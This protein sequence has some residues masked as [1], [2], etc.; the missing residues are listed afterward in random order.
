M[1]LN[2][3]RR[4]P[5]IPFAAAFAA[6]GRLRIRP[7]LRPRTGPGAALAAPAAPAALAA[8]AAPAALA[9]AFLLGA[10]VLLAGM[11][12]GPTPPAAADGTLT[13]DSVTITSTPAAEDDYHAGETITARVTFS[14]AITAHTGATLTFAIGLNNRVA[15]LE[16]ATGLNTTTLDFSYVVTSFD[17]DGTGIA[18]AANAIAGTYEHSGHATGTHSI[19]TIGTPLTTAQTAHKVNTTATVGL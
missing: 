10:A 11:L 19:T 5:R 12:A 2:R 13:A 16:D 6:A 18:I 1:L 17:Q 15:T 8:P 9:L 4:F 7:R 14:Q 3:N